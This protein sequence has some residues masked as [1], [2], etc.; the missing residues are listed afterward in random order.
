MGRARR[1]VSWWA[2]C[3]VSGGKEVRTGFIREGFPEKGVVKLD[4]DLEN[5][6]ECVR[7]RSRRPGT[8]TEARKSFVF[9]CL[10]VCGRQRL[11]KGGWRGGWGAG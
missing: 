10:C 5:E 1:D 11:R 9:V 2:P 4:P 8:I 6:Q 3:R 7:L